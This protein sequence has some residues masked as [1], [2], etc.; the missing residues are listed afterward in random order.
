MET[1]APGTY[2]KEKG[3]KKEKQRKEDRKEVSKKGRKKKGERERRKELTWI[4]L[5]QIMFFWEVVQACLALAGRK[6][7]QKGVNLGKGSKRNRCY[8]LLQFSG[9][10]FLFPFT[11]KV[12]TTSYH[13]VGLFPLFCRHF[14]VLEMR[15]TFYPAYWPVHRFN[16]HVE[17]SPW[18]KSCSYL[19]PPGKPRSALV[20]YLPGAGV[21]F[22]PGHQETPAL[23]I[24]ILLNYP[25][26]YPG[27]LASN[28]SVPI[29]IP[30]TVDPWTVPV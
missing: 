19:R 2:G 29:P 13:Y 21:Y 5:M 3:R 16:V 23:N 24:P 6:F 15:A 14:T 27:C 4:C 10:D 1:D 12:C 26:G 25:L 28:S 7:S 30:I 18:L 8:H 11:L 17:L 22:L 9:L 20:T